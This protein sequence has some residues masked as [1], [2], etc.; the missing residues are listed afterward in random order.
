MI[1]YFLGILDGNNLL[2]QVNSW[3][4]SIFDRRTAQLRWLSRHGY[5]RSSG[6]MFPTLPN[7]KISNFLWPKMI[8]YS[9]FAS[10]PA[11]QNGLKIDNTNNIKIIIE[12]SPTKIEGLCERDGVVMFPLLIF[13][14]DTVLKICEIYSHQGSGFYFILSVTHEL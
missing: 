10:I 11:S 2:V 9:P 14:R 8:W 6:H 12:S 3:K 13:K 7:L 5:D 1:E 4:Y